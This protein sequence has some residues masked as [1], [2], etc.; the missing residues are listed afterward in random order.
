MVAGVGGGH[1]AGVGCGVG[2]GV[3]AAV[4]AAVGTGVGAAVG[5][6]VG[7]G[8][9]A[10]VGGAGHSS[11]EYVGS[12]DLVRAH[13]VLTGAEIWPVVPLVG[14]ISSVPA[15]SSLALRLA[16]RAGQPPRDASDMSI[17]HGG[18]MIK[19]ALHPNFVSSSVS[20]RGN[21]SLSKRTV[22][23]SL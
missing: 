1:G 7:A 8:V 15:G 19:R 23:Q 11:D 14:Y 21:I 20:I 4:G 10:G 5:T 9:G 13:A 16:R 12:Y 22:S 3:G 6:G 17:Y 2:D 18:P